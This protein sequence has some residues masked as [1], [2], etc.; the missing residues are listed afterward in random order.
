M[1]LNLEK[2]SRFTTELRTLFPEYKYIFK[3]PFCLRDFSEPDIDT[4]KIIDAHI[5]PEKLGGRSKTVA[6]AECDNRIGH[7]I[8]GPMI[9]FLY[10]NEI[11]HG[12]R[13]GKVWGK[14]YARINDKKYRTQIS[15]TKDKRILVHLPIPQEVDE[16]FKQDFE[17]L[18]KASIVYEC[19]ERIN[20][21]IVSPL[22]L[23]MAYLAAFERYGY[24]YIFH[25]ELNWIRDVLNDVRKYKIPYKCSFIPSEPVMNQ[26]PKKLEYALIP[27]KIKSWTA[28]TFMWKACVV[29]L[30]PFRDGKPRQFVG[31]GIEIGSNVEFKLDF[32]SNDEPLFGELTFNSN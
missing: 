2:L 5:I 10:A 18:K 12:R 30:P 28:P 6:C 3:C 11:M 15:G 9:N 8:E 32:D 7:E 24:R 1:S 19:S 20:D 13:I 25:P 29:L 31:F 14:T 16:F 4:N 26:L 22:F 27:M 17:N 21:E 23:K